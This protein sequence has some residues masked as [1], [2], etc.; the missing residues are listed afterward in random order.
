[1]T[2]YVI[3]KEAYQKP[4]EII[5]VCMSEQDAVDYIK[6]TY[7]FFSIPLSGGKKYENE[8]LKVDLDRDSS[9]STHL[10]VLRTPLF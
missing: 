7:S 5:G 6:N 10:Y 8:V 1:M 4:Y 2:A 3:V 9:T